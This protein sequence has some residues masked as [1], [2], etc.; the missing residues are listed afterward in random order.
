MNLL[1]PVR[2]SVVK[3]LLHHFN[4]MPV[5]Y[6]IVKDRDGLAVDSNYRPHPYQGCALAT[7]LQARLIEMVELVGSN[8]TTS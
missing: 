4:A 2:Y 6:S 8:A 5:R 3:D 7:E 1:L